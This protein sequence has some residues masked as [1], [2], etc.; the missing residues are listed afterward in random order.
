MGF[1]VYIILPGDDLP[2]PDE[3]TFMDVKRH[4][5]A[6]IFGGNIGARHLET[7]VAAHDGIGELVGASKHPPQPESQGDEDDGQNGND[8][9]APQ[10]HAIP[11]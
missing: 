6:R 8:D 4:Q 1:E 11:P 5:A 9:R 10:L 2:R 7:A 3:I